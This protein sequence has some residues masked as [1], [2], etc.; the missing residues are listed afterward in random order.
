MLITP[1]SI[2]VFIEKESFLS[3]LMDG[4]MDD[5]PWMAKCSLVIQT[6]MT[7]QDDEMRIRHPFAI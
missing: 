2:D 7:I 1:P 6:W 3:A 4:Q 5:H